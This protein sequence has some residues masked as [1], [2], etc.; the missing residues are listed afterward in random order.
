MNSIE[1]NA[2]ALSSFGLTLKQAKVYL[3]VVFL[4]TAVVGEI[5]KHSKVRREEVYRIL[6]KLKKM[7]LIEK[8]L[9][10]PVQLK[11]TPVENALSILIRNEE[12]NAK[13]RIIEL[14]AKKEQFLEHFRTSSK[15]TK[16]GGDQF[17]LTSEKAVTL[18]KI[19]SLIDSAQ[20]QIECI[21]SREKVLQFAKYFSESIN[22][23]LERGV[24]LKVI[25]NHPKDADD[26]PVIINRLFTH[27]N[28][29]SVRYL[30]NL[31]NHFIIIDNKEV[32]TAT[33]T[34]GYLADYPLLWSNN[35]P[36]V[37][38]YKK[39]FEDLWDSS[40]ALVALNVNTDV[41]RL[42]IC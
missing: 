36:H 20:T 10:T 28:A 8:T 33:S 19:N 17:S 32:L 9:S 38:V 16:L 34:E 40:V 13:N 7:G 24:K 1:Q 14:T 41:E 37:M 39:L 42:A 31:P 29:I 27:K 15:E 3:S 4:G 23:A 12:E 6:P 18:G 26:L 5:S 35:K 21:A 25:S 30:E 22:E 2:E 11:A